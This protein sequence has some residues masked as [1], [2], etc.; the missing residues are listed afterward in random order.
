[1]SVVQSRMG[2]MAKKFAL[3][4]KNSN[5]KG[6]RKSEE[7]KKLVHHKVKKKKENS[8]VVSLKYKCAEQLQDCTNNNKLAFNSLNTSYFYN[9]F[10]FCHDFVVSNSCGVFRFKRVTLF[11]QHF[12]LYRKQV[13][14]Q[15]SG[16][17]KQC[18]SKGNVSKQVGW[19]FIPSLSLNS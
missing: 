10:F 6:C 8:Q 9:C 17:T 1:M 15:P 16:G 18:T 3:I 2:Y 7:K 12:S 11:T 13:C 19:L 4:L 14:K 5:G